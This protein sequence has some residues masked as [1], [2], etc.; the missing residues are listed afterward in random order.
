MSVYADHAAQLAA[1]YNE[2]GGEAPTFVWD[3]R[4]WAILPGG[5]KFRRVNAVGGLELNS[6]LQLTCLAAQFG[7]TLPQAGDQI[8]YTGLAYTIISITPA[9]AGFQMRINADLTVQGM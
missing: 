4:P 1:L 3:E 7:G 6:D 8:V 9:P 2:L 5:A